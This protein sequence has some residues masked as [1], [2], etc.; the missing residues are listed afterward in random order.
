MALCD[1]S[2]D[3]WFEDLRWAWNEDKTR[4][5]LLDIFSRRKRFSP[6]Q[7]RLWCR[8]VC[9]Y[10]REGWTA[11]Q[12]GNQFGVG[13]QNIRRIIQSLRC[14]AARF[15]G[16]S[17]T[18]RQALPI[19]ESARK[20][21]V[22]ITPDPTNES[23]EYW[24]AVLASHGLYDPD[25]RARGWSWENPE[26]KFEWQS[27]TSVHAFGWGEFYETQAKPKPTFHTI[28]KTG[29]T[30]SWGKAKQVG[31]KTVPIL[32]GPSDLVLGESHDVRIFE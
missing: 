28:E 15:F 9:L 22:P 17:T 11:R 2:L 7:G 14:E 18:T 26:Y 31:T 32:C 27:R 29:G 10:W 8:V 19:V 6:V 16:Q 21:R 1:D 25:R 5:L 23:Q 20:S 24:N 3:V 13:L 12:I 4:A 30:G